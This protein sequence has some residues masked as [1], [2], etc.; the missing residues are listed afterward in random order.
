MNPLRLLRAIPLPL[1]NFF[2]NAWDM[3]TYLS[4]SD[5]FVGFSAVLVLANLPRLGSFLHSNILSYAL[6]TN[7]FFLRGVGS[8]AAFARQ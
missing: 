7:S 2:V 5:A 6:H 4:Y 1:L 8:F 3:A